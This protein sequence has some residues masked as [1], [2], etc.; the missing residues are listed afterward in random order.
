MCSFNLIIIENDGSLKSKL[1]RGYERSQPE[2]SRQLI[3]LITE[4]NGLDR[5]NIAQLVRNNHLITISTDGRLID[6]PAVDKRAVTVS[7]N[8]SND[9]TLQQIGNVYA[10]VEYGDLSPTLYSV[11]D[12]VV[13]D[14][15]N[16]MWSY[17]PYFNSDMGV[18]PASIIDGTQ[19]RPVEEL[20]TELER[21]AN[22][23]FGD[24]DDEHINPALVEASEQYAPLGMTPKEKEEYYRQQ[25]LK[26]IEADD[27]MYK[28]DAKFFE[29][30]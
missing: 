28:E 25:L 2:Y 12:T 24:C 13:L 9:G 7:S 11:D 6:N 23:E 14:T 5:M 16:W 1:I 19:L 3:K 21:C 29:D 10:E 8:I 20:L 30:D 18:D 27:F 17:A 26:E 4:S 22:E 15:R